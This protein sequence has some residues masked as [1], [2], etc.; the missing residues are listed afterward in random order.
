MRVRY[1]RAQGGRALRCALDA[2]REYARALAGVKLA[3]CSANLAD[4]HANLADYHANLSDRMMTRVTCRRSGGARAATAS[5][6]AVCYS[7]HTETRR[8]RLG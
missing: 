1:G 6:R 2:P 4:Y 5:Q 7:T 3:D 8:A